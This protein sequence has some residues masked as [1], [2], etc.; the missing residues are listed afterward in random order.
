[1]VYHDEYTP[2]DDII[3]LGKLQRDK[4]KSSQG[5][6]VPKQRKHFESVQMAKS[7]NFNHSFQERANTSVNSI[8]M[9]SQI[10]LPKE[11]FTYKPQMRKFDL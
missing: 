4:V 7:H 9:E 3:N 2:R 1:M 5:L 11:R 6:H 10:T 8:D